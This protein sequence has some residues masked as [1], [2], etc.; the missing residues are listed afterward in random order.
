M[1]SDGGAA[2]GG[3]GGRDAWPTLAMLDRACA[4]TDPPVEA[5][6]ADVTLARVLRRITR[7]YLQQRP[8]RALRR[9]E[10]VLARLPATHPSLAGI[11]S[12]AAALQ[13]LDR[14]RSLS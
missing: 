6:A 12:T 13:H 5:A 10:S 8:R 4:L 7:A 2:S 1:H 3:S 11:Q 14:A 9:A